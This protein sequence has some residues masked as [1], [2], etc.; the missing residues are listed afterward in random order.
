MGLVLSSVIPS[1]LQEVFGWHARP[2][3]LSRLT[4]PWQPVRV[5]VEPASLRDGQAVLRL[6]GGL[7]WVAAHQPD[8]YDP[9]HR[10]VDQ[11]V[12]PFPEI[13]PWRHT[14]E[15]SPSDADATLVTDRVDTA[16][17]GALLRPIFQYRHLQLSE[18][19]AALAQ[20]RRWGSEPMTVAVTGASGLVGSAV[21]ALLSTSG[22]Q[23]IRLVRR[24]ARSDDERYWR[25]DLVSAE[26]LG[27]VD[28]V[29]HLAGAS[30]AGRFTKDRMAAIRDSR[31]EPTRRLVQSA[32]RAT[33]G[34]RVFVSASAIGYYGP[35]RG[36]EVLTEDSARGDGFLADVVTEWEDA[37]RPAADADIRCVQVRTGIVQSPAGGALRLQYPLFAAGLGGRLGHGQQ[38]LS[39]IGIDDLADI[40]RRAVLDDSLTGPVNAV[41]PHP[42]RQ[43]EYARTLARVVRR[44]A[45]LP[46]P[47]FGPR[48]LLGDRGAEE[49]ALAG[50]RVEADRLRHAGHQFRHPDLETALR[51]VLGRR[52]R[53]PSR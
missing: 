1:P 25:P 40:Y 48:L 20:A 4:P 21:I 11:R 18:D 13:L 28:A 43:R 35:D 37:V 49:V 2:G 19:L 15:F 10:F 34:P 38:W 29:I 39:W 7:R 44:P 5:L 42:V 6:P 31:V 52:S 8:G 50:Q 26:L 17:P 12:T 47:E 27:G 24:P 30:I 53:T 14:H 51:H 41:A 33:D 3:A 36:E 9:P 46:V 23:V 16:V 32:T 45:L 22:H